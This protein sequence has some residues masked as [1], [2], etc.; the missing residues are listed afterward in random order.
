[1][2]VS[3]DLLIKE[4]R[5]R[6]HSVHLF[7]ATHFGYR[8]PDPNTYRFPAAETPW[9]KGYPLAMPPFY[10]LIYRFRKIQPDIV[11]TH[12]PWTIGFVG[13]RWA[14]SHQVPIVTT[15]HTHYDKYSH[16]I[17]Y[18]PKP[19][20]RYKIAKHTNYYYNRVNHVI[21][22]SEASKKWLMRHSVKTP[23]SVIP[24]GIQPP[25]LLDRA[26]IR[27]RFGLR[28]ET[29]VLLYTG[30]IAQEKNM[31]TLFQGCAEIL[32]QEPNTVLW[33]V[34]DGPYRDGCAELARDLG[35][36]DRVKF[37]GF[38]PRDQVDQYYAL[39]DLFLF[40]ST[41]E[42]Q[43]LVVAEAMSYGLPPVVVAGGGA[44]EPIDDGVSG[45]RVQDDPFELADRALELLNSD[46]L[47][48][49]FSAAA[50]AGIHAYTPGAMAE[51]ILGVY[52]NV[53]DGRPEY[54]LV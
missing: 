11:H 44:S 16:Y 37:L 25:Q 31:D 9:S 28:P 52:R 27:A 24:T 47:Y 42:T 5:Q 19:Y 39:A 30:R 40:T 49:K 26:E 20:V 23:I 3:I 8:D 15:Y 53:L 48:A 14:E 10:P 17:P 4:L 45:F 29:R 41:T 2:S 43:G 46:R 51:S 13:M 38:V 54:S 34:G 33:L 18:V 35:I 6:G 36:G 32:G 22:P 12:T 7:T 21:T 1:M 50:R